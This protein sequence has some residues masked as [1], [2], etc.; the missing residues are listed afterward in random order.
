[1]SLTK[2]STKGSALTYNEMDDNFTHLGGDGTYQFPSTDGSSDQVLA[3][4]GSGQLSFVNQSGPELSINDSNLNGTQFKALS[5]KRILKISQ[6]DNITFDIFQPV[7][8]DVGKSWT[9]MNADPSSA[10]AGTPIILSFDSQYFRFL[11]GSSALGNKWDWKVN[12]GGLAEIV[13]V[14][15]GANGGSNTAPNFVIYGAGIARHQ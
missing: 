2:R 6:T 1:M 9:I 11:D 13:C 7:A 10:G 8:A 3:T 15:Y 5:G 12:R 14:A 4:N